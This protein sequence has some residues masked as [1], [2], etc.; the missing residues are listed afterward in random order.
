MKKATLEALARENEFEAIGKEWMLITAGTPEKFN[1]MTASWGGLGWLWNKPVAFIFVR[2]ERYTY[3]FIEA[4]DHLT[5]S[6]YGHSPAMRRV[7]NLCGAVSGRDHD[8]LKET[9]LTPVTTDHGAVTFEEARLTIEGRKLFRSE[10]KAEEFIDP[11]CLS[12]WYGNHPGGSLHT[13]YVV[14]IENVYEGTEQG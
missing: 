9:G 2:P 14:E 4:N 8:K 10:M 1:M 7:V 13:V 12:K 5:L 11:E 6:F 3:P